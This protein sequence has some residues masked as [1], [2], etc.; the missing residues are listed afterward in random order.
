MTRWW[1]QIF[2]YFHP[3]LGKIPILT[4]IF[5]MGWNHQL[6]DISKCQVYNL[7]WFI[8]TKQ[9]VDS[10]QISEMEPTLG[11]QTPC[12]EVF[13]PPKTYLKH[14]TSGG[15]TGRLG[16]KQ[17]KLNSQ[18]TAGIRKEIKLCF[19]KFPHEY[20]WKV[21]GPFVLQPELVAATSEPM[22]SFFCWKISNP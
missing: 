7:Q 18:P 8:F 1:F 6:D 10:I 15:M 9:T 2:F 20:G 3:Y 22:N 11:F 16:Q 17:I 12:E 13:W 21:P 5:Q 19:W 14:R 4:N